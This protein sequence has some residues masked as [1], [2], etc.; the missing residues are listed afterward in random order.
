MAEAVAL[1]ILSH[2]LRPPQRLLVADLGPPVAPDQSLDAAAYSATMVLVT[3]LST[4]PGWYIS[5]L[6]YCCWAAGCGRGGGAA[7]GS[8]GQ[9]CGR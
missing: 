4:S 8:W 1:V 7:R 5:D 6:R 2:L 3:M 9:R